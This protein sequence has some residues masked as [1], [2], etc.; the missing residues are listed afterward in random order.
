[1]VNTDVYLERNAAARRAPPAQTVRGTAP[2]EYTERLREGLGAERERLDS[3]TH[4]NQLE[5]RE[6]NDTRYTMVALGGLAVGAVAY[7]C[8]RAYCAR[9]DQQAS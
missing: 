8:Y 1:M 9:R 2:Q 5:R 3:T 6:P 7:R 4:A